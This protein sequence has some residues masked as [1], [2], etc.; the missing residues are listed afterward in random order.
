[1]DYKKKF[2]IVN[3]QIISEH[4]IIHNSVDDFIML[5]ESKFHVLMFSFLRVSVGEGKRTIW[6]FLNFWAT[7]MHKI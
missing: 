3:L 6:L 2:I 4:T 7:N 1:M 5:I